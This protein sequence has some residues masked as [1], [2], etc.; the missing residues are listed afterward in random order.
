MKSISIFNQMVSMLFVGIMVINSAQAQETSFAVDLMQSMAKSAAGELGSTMM[1]WVL[2]SAGAT[3]GDVQVLNEILNELDTIEN[4]LEDIDEELEVL[5]EAIDQLDCDTWVQNAEPMVN[6]ISNLWNPYSRRRRSLSTS[7]GSGSTTT[8][9]SNQFYVGLVKEAQ[10]NSITTD[11]IQSF[12]DAVL[13]NDNK[14]INQLSIVDYLDD[15][16]RVLIPPAGGSGLIQSC[17][18]LPSVG[19]SN[20][21]GLTDDA[22]YNKT[23][24][25]LIQYYYSIQVQGMTMVVEASNYQAY[26]AA[27]SPLGTTSNITDLPEQICG[28]T[29]Q[30]TNSSGTYVVERNVSSPSRD[31]Y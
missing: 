22:Y 27:G 13:N 10:Q 26:L 11:A 9:T 1:G 17:L 20:Y 30:Y 5:V 25:A 31:Y 4:T 15:L 23:A 21:P 7:T 18:G 6:A 29:T 2:G 28:N 24:G 3:N 16:S 12:V 14:G 8:S 19:P